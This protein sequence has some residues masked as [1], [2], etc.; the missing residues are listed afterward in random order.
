MTEEQV[1]DFEIAT[2]ARTYLLPE[3]DFDKEM[4]EIRLRLKQEIN[5]K[6]CMNLRSKENLDKIFACIKDALNK[7]ADEAEIVIKTLEKVSL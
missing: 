4:E 2:F 5:Q 3:N 1:K 6:V 7:R